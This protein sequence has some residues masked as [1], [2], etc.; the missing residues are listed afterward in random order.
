MARDDW[1]I[2]I[3]LPEE[4]H[5]H[6]L[7]GRLGALGDDTARRLEEELEGR[8]LAVT[9]DDSTV[10]VYVASR[11]EAESAQ[12]VVQA[13]LAETGIEATLV[14]LEHWLDDEDRWDDEPPGET[15]EQDELDRGFAPWE[16][17]IDKGTRGAAE[18]LT[19]QLE[20]EG[21]P[22]VRSFSYVIV[23]AASEAEARELAER[24]GGEV[25]GGGEVV[26]ET[27][28]GNPFAIFGGLGGD[29]APL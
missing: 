14:R 16:V 22:V 28:P 20:A 19:K 13:E 2:R 29:A 27:A 9:R 15:W 5:A 26:W 6:G 18:E 23:G 12:R 1:R 17:R 7:L 10:F 4:E 11:L 24:I 8:R 3:E 21:L 25:E